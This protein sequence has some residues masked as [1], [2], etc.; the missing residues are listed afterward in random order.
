MNSSWIDNVGLVAAVSLPL[1]NIPLIVR[2]VKRKSSRDLSLIW[3][4]GVWVCIVLMFPSG[5]RSEDIVW[6]V[7]NIVNITFFTM[8]VLVTLKYRG[9]EGA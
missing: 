6:K 3:V 9:G 4:L 1:F 7:F 8:V 2:I 5:M